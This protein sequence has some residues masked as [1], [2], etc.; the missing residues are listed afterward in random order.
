MHKSISSNYVYFISICALFSNSL[1]IFSNILSNSTLYSLST[2]FKYIF[3]ILLSHL[4][5]IFFIHCWFTATTT[6]NQLSTTTNPTQPHHRPPQTNKNPPPLPPH[7]AF[8]HGSMNKSSSW[9]ASAKTQSK[10][11]L[12]QMVLGFH[13]RQ[14]IMELLRSWVQAEIGSANPPPQAEIYGANPKPRLRNRQPPRQAGS[15]REERGKRAGEN[16][17]TEKRKEKKGK[18]EKEI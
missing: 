14:R 18:R 6:V 9:W 2:L 16:G 1:F 12:M 7:V 8:T 5:I 4:N 3:F 17:R 15:S 10:W 11:I 13:R